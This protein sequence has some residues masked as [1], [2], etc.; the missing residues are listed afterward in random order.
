[1]KGSISPSERDAAA[2]AAARPRSSASKA[3]PGK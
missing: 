3:T 1:V 2:R